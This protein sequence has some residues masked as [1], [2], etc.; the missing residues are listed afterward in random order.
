MKNDTYFFP[1]YSHSPEMIAAYMATIKKP[2]KK[3]GP[4][5]RQKAAENVLAVVTSTR[6]RGKTTVADTVHNKSSGLAPDEYVIE[7]ILDERTTRGKK[8]YLVRWVGY[9]ASANQWVAEEN[10][11]YIDDDDEYEVE[12]ILSDRIRDGK[13]E[14]LV[15]WKGFSAKFDKWVKDVDMHCPELMK[16]YSKNKK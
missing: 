6:S 3:L 4:K 16:E 13:N 1:C 12:T 14:Y 2:T 5:S 10:T 15:R 11:R 9:N 8:E 7:E